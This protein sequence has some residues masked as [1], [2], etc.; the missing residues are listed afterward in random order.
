MWEYNHTPNHDELYHHGTKG[1]KWGVRKNKTSTSSTRKKRLKERIMDISDEDLQKRT[2]RIR[3]EM[4]YKQAVYESRMKKATQFIDI[5]N[6]VSDG[7]NAASN[8][9]NSSSKVINSTAKF[10]DQANNPYKNVSGKNKKKKKKEKADYY[11]KLFK[12]KK[13]G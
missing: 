10:M 6:K 3:T 1:M 13:K 8:Y 2:K 7:A 5:I 9:L 4:N 11:I 12:K